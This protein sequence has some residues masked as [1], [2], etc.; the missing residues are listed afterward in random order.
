MEKSI[1]QVKKELASKILLNAKAINFKGGKYIPPMTE[2]K[3]P[4]KG[5]EIG[6]I[7]QSLNTET[8]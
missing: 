1:K 6:G 3:T 8:I 5:E 4:G 2:K 7:G